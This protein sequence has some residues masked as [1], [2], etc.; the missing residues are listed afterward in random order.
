MNPTAKHI[1]HNHLGSANVITTPTAL[2]VQFMLHLPY[3]EEFV[4]QLNSTYDERFTFTDKE[5]DIETGYY[6]FGARFDNVDLGFMSVD[7]MSDKY[8]SISPY[9]YCAWNPIKLVDPTGED[10]KDPPANLKYTIQK[11]DN[12][13]NLE[14]EWNLPH[15]TLQE[16]NPSIE[17]HNLQIGQTINVAKMDEGFIIVGNDVIIPNGREMETPNEEGPIGII[18][19]ASSEDFLQFR[20]AFETLLYEMGADFCTSTQK[21]VSSLKK[22][23]SRNTTWQY[24]RNHSMIKWNNEFKKRGWSE[25]QVSETI[26]RGEAIPANNKINPNNKATRYKNKTTEKSV[27]I[28]KQTRELIHVGSKDFKYD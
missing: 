6:Y 5:K 3:G 12:F 15:G 25:T 27:V 14:T 19:M 26:R 4:K 13:W 9:A 11:G 22:I 8:P 7:P 24:G 1:N 21:I 28:D 2:P 20:M 10:I 18:Q 17:P 23:C 16:I